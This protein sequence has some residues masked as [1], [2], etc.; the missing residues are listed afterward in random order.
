MQ[1]V[2]TVERPDPELGPAEPDPVPEAAGAAPRRPRGARAGRMFNT[3][4]NWPKGTLFGDKLKAIVLTPTP[5][6]TRCSTR[7]TGST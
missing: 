3:V 1:Q 2:I 7:S 6:S 4:R 5:R